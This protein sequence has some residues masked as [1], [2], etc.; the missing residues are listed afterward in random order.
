MSCHHQKDQGSPVNVLGVGLDQEPAKQQEKEA[1]DRM[2]EPA[3][4]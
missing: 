3:A 1:K 4:A 2:Q